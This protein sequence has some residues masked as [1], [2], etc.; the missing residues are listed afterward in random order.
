MTDLDRRSMLAGAT[1]SAAQNDKFVCP[2]KT[3]IAKTAA[4]TMAITWALCVSGLNSRKHSQM[5]APK[6]TVATTANAV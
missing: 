6:N 4:H 1:L 2:V 5:A 3:E